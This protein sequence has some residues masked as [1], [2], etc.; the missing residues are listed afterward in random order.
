MY[1]EESV[2]LLEPLRI[3]LWIL[4]E[5]TD[6]QRKQSESPLEKARVT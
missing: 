4:Q 2:E 3:A 6:C 1:R 5:S